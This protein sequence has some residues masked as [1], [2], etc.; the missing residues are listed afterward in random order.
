MTARGLRPLTVFVL[1]AAIL[2]GLAPGLVNAGGDPTPEE[3]ERIRQQQQ[4]GQAPPAEDKTTGVLKRT[5]SPDGITSKDLEDVLNDEAYWRSLREWDAQ[6]APNPSRGTD[7]AGTPKPATSTVEQRPTQQPTTT[8]AQQVAKP[9]TRVTILTASG[10]ADSVVK[11]E[12]FIV[13]VTPPPGTNL[14]DSFEVTITT[15][16]GQKETLT[17]EKN[18]KDGV[19]TYRSRPLTAAEGQQKPGWRGTWLPGGTSRSV[20]P[21]KVTNG[22]EITIAYGNEASTS[23]RVYDTQIMQAIA[24]H[25]QIFNRRAEELVWVVQQSEG[26]LRRID[27]MLKS[28]TD[29]AQRRDLEGARADFEQARAVAKDKLQYI[30]DARRAIAAPPPATGPASYNDIRQFVLGQAYLTWLEWPDMKEARGRATEGVMESIT[31]MAR[32]RNLKIGIGYATVLYEQ[33]TAMTGAGAAYQLITGQDIYGREGSRLRGAAEL[34]LTIAVGRA[35][36][37]VAAAPE[38]IIAEGGVHF[39]IVVSR[40]GVPKPTPGIPTHIVG[41]SGRTTWMNL[42]ED[43]LPRGSARQVRPVNNGDSVLNRLD[44]TALGEYPRAGTP[45]DAAFFTKAGLEPKYTVEIGGQRFHVSKPFVGAE[46][47]TAVIAFQE[48]ANGTVVPRTFYISNEHGVWRAATGTSQAKNLI[49]K[50]PFKIVD[51]G[52]KEIT[53]QQ[54]FEKG[55]QP[56][57]ANEGAVDV[58]AELQGPLHR[59]AGQQ[60]PLKLADDVMERA[61]FNHLERV[62]GGLGQEPAEFASFVSRADVELPLAK[63]GPRLAGGLRPDVTI[64]DQWSFNSPIYGRLDGALFRSQN[65]QALYVALRDSKGRTFVP[66]IQNAEAGITPF[67]TRTTTFQSNVTLN[68][69]PVNLTAT[70]KVHGDRGYID[71]R[72]FGNDLTKYFDRTVP[73]AGTAPPAPRPPA[74]PS[75]SVTS[76]ATATPSPVGPRPPS[77]TPG[78]PSAADVTP[79]V[80]PDAPLRPEVAQAVTGMEARGEAAAVRRVNMQRAVAEAREDSGRIDVRALAEEARAKGIP[81][82]RIASVVLEVARDARRIEGMVPTNPTLQGALKDAVYAHGQFLLASAI[83]ERENPNARSISDAAEID[84]VDSVKKKARQEAKGEPQTWTPGEVTKLKALAADAQWTKTWAK[85]SPLD[86]QTPGFTPLGDETDAA[87]V[88]A[89]AR[90]VAQLKVAPDATEGGSRDARR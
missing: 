44:K 90:R 63:E 37:R 81:D 29:A 84:L 51:S 43:T 15:A 12:P 26:A 47:K 85:R 66:S 18:V 1:L 45:G 32:D 76:P 64:L 2:I 19:T 58:A 35:I 42:P 88:T 23:T 48:T 4:R 77:S 34:V 82:A 86:Y 65:G 71:V 33:V 87:A 89:T 49:H 28:T 7:T 30:A 54:W 40:G 22:D 62:D 60:Q 52:G 27:E 38:A 39:E 73:H 3:Q 74:T 21:L 57:F 10:G 13:V 79:A 46:G 17:I 70:P 59:W 36:K 41:R 75:A 83:F 69:K 67:G 9:K 24:R 31:N 14:P 80:R 78:T 16:D 55:G 68:G 20:D 53:K 11:T 56:V 5:T 25:E 50:G 72:N 8:P 61:Y 6:N